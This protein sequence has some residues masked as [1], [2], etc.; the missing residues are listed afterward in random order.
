MKSFSPVKSQWVSSL[1]ILFLVSIL[2]GCST[3]TISPY[4]SVAYQQAT[5]LKVDSIT[6]M[7]KASTP[8][9]SHLSEISDL[10]NNL[11]KAY[12]YSKGRPSNQISTEQWEILL[13]PNR[14]SLGGFLELWK[15]KQTLNQFFIIEAEKLVSKDFDEIIRLESGKKKSDTLPSTQ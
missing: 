5:A 9:S 15:V 12:E 2:I 1:S 11:S 6:L 13:D 4:S 3:S 7:N 14:N 10:Q 8:Y